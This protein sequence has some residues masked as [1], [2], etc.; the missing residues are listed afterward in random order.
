MQVNTDR[1]DIANDLRC[2][3]LRTSWQLYKLYEKQNVVLQHNLRHK[4]NRMTFLGVGLTLHNHPLTEICCYTYESSSP[5]ATVIVMVH[6]YHDI[7]D[8][9]AQQQAT[10]NDK[11][12]RQGSWGLHNLPLRHHTKLSFIV[13]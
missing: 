13:L 1:I 9:Q 4:S 6:T 7:H 2:M 5:E 10:G 8:G 11:D 12:Y 3:C